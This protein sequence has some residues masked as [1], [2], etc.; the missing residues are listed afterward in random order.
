MALRTLVVDGIEWTAWDVVPAAPSRLRLT[1][2]SAAMQQGWLC[3]E[4][5][6]EKRRVA[7]V[8]AGWAGWSDEELAG[9]LREAARVAP[10]EQG[11]GGIFG[12]E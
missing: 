3:F 4:S 1:G 8:P 7:P 11:G 10:R 12:G 6:G 9:C 2:S 5:S